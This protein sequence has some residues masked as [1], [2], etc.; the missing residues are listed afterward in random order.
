MK[1]LGLVEDTPILSE[2]P[3]GIGRC[4]LYGRARNKMTRQQIQDLRAMKT[5]SVYENL[6]TETILFCE[7]QDLE[8]HNLAEVRTSRK[9]KM[10]GEISSDERI[11]SAN[12]RYVCEVYRCSLDVILSKLDDRFSGSENIFKEF[13]LLLPERL[14]LNKVSPNKFD[15][16]VNWLSADR[17]NKIGLN[18]EYELF[19]S[20]YKNFMNSAT[21]NDIK[22]QSKHTIN[23]NDLS[24]QNDTDSDDS[25][26]TI[27]VTAIYSA[28]CKMGMVS[29]F[30]NLFMVYKGICTLP[31]TSATA[32]RCFSKLKLIKTKLRSTVGEKRLDN[33]MLIS[34]NPDIEVSIEDAINK[35]AS[36]SSVLQKALMY[37]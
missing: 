9:K 1:I 2:R 32:E 31:P 16:L 21:A 19:A 17:I 5:E 36:T 15:Y 24:D 33:L 6:F 23:T 10:S 37:C 3:K 30:P 25:E 27:H 7:A 34:C 4:Y 18:V 20:N 8:E 29:A 22:M 28:L 35:F 12:Y 26:E 11:T 13:S 14:E